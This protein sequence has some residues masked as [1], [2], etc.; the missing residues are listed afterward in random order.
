MFKLEFKDQR[1]SAVWLVE[2]TIKLGS[3]PKNHIVLIETGVEPLHAEIRK[4][5]DTLYLSDCQTPAGTF[6]NGSAV[7]QNFQLREGDKIKIAGVEMLIVDP[8]QGG[9]KPLKGAGKAGWSL[10]ALSGGLKGKSINVAGAMVFGRSSGCDIVI[11]DAHMSR[12]HAEISLKNGQLRIVDLQSSNGTCVNGQRVGEQALKPGDKISFDHIVFLV[13]GP[14]GAVVTDDQEEDEDE[15]TVFRAA[16]IPRAPKP[17]VAPQAVVPT[18]QMS[19][20][21]KEESVQSSSKGLWL[22]IGVVVLAAIGAAVYFILG[23]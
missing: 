6:V 20:H 22:V 21:D 4:D 5:G 14:V 18:P 9:A 10:M 11:Q 23:Q 15:A 8:K 12:R 2:S 3:D 7:T 16:P 13:A 1:Q 19:E 17:K